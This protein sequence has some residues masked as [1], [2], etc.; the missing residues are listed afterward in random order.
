MTYKLNSAPK[1]EGAEDQ[2]VVVYE[3]KEKNDEKTQTFTIKFSDPENDRI[4]S[5]G[6]FP[7][8]KWLKTGVVGS[9]LNIKGVKITIDKS[10]ISSTD[11]GKKTFYLSV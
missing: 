5:F 8:K 11:N 2:K 6:L 10:Q 4:T 7:R 3:D 1:I 9:R